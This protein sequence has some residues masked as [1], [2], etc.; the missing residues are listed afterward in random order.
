MP[1]GWLKKILGDL[2]SLI[3]VAGALIAL[4]IWVGNLKNQV[5]SSQEEVSRLKGQVQ[6][7][8]DILQ[9]TQASVADTLRGP[10]GPKGDRGEPGPTGP[11]GVPGERGP[12]GEVGPSGAPGQSVDADTVLSLIQ[13]VIKSSPEATSQSSTT[14]L[15]LQVD[16]FDS[17]QC[18]SE[19]VF[20][21]S[22][23]IVVTE[24]SQICSSSGEILSTIKKIDDNNMIVIEEP[25]VG[26]WGCPS[27]GKCSFAFNKKRTFN[28][29][30]VAVKNGA[31]Y[32]SL[33]MHNK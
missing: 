32:V 23:V 25:G 27:T 15:G 18:T 14:S 22:P 19:S 20:N 24:G 3:T 8:Q 31:K 2:P 13:S 4:G 5:D 9:K 26:S 33:R 29:E 6:Q 10:Q 28:F 16:L 30:R 21:N 7:L 1:D 17:S 11:Q 12:Q